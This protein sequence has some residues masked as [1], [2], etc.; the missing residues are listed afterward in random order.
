MKHFGKGRYYLFTGRKFPS[1]TKEGRAAYEALVR[2]LAREVKQSV[3]LVGEGEA[4]QECIAYAVY[5]N[6]IYFLNMHT[7]RKQ[8]FAYEMG[9]R[10]FEMTL[11]PCEINVVARPV[12]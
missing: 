12:K 1:A 10:R 5:Q 4:P 11:A 9:E 6:K 7:R 8:T 3:R 2:R